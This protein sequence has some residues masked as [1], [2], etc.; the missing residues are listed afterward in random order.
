MVY[1]PCAFR[2]SFINQGQAPVKYLFFLLLVLFSVSLSHGEERIVY[3]SQSGVGLHCSTRIRRLE[4]FLREL[5]P[6]MSH[7]PGKLTIDITGRG[8]PLEKIR[9]ERIELSCF[10]IE[11]FSL[12]ALSRAGSALLY[13]NGKVSSRDFRLPLFV[14]GA[15]RH[16]ERSL[17]RESLFLNSNRRFNTVESLLREGVMPDLKILLSPQTETDGSAAALWFDD[18]SRLFL[19]LLRRRKSRYTPEEF[20]KAAVQLASEKL[21]PE[22]LYPLIWNSFNLLPPSLV[23]PLLDKLLQCEFRELDKDN[24]PGE[25]MAKCSAGQLPL[26]M[27]QH[28]LRLETCTAFAKQLNA[29]TER[30]PREL[31]PHLRCFT[32]AV[33]R[34]GKDPEYEKEYLKALEQLN[35]KASYCAR[36]ADFLDSLTLKTPRAAQLWNSSIRENSARGGIASPECQ[37]YLDRCEKY[38]TGI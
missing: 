5:F 15:F 1:F 6:G 7:T 16:R 34:L 33:R 14:Y 17:D 22:E 18:H 31:H 30:F 27:R 38:Y 35:E 19:E 12:H 10:E 26:K 29:H 28:P 20:Q 3:R 8:A 11:N 9:G 24:Q 37:R 21:Y 32:E 36:R 25:N 13:A 2:A 23:R 4:Q